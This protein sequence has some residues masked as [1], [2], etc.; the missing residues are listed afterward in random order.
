MRCLP[1]TVR[2]DLWSRLCCLLGEGVRVFP[3]DR[4]G[5]RPAYRVGDLTSGIY[6]LRNQIAHGDRIRKQYL[7]RIEFRF[8]PAI[9]EYLRIGE[10]TS[11]SL[12]IEAALFTLGAALR[13]V[14]LDGHPELLKEPR[15]LKNYLDGRATTIRLIPPNESSQTR[16]AF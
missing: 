14:I 11:Q 3:G 4:A 16:L 13:K 5:R 1:R 15:A 8:E 7:E 2:H 6:Q 9:P 10:W 12:L